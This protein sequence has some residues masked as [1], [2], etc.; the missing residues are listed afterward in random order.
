MP[1]LVTIIDKE[2]REMKKII[3]PWGL[4]LKRHII[5]WLVKRWFPG[6]HIHS[7]PIRKVID[8]VAP[9]P[10]FSVDGG[11]NETE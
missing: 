9:V 2:E 8:F 5:L 10:E 7:N 11:K 3:K 4:N 6:H 1:G